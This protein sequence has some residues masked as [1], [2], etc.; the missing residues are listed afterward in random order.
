[1]R[2]TLGFWCAFLTIASVLSV[3]DK[4]AHASTVFSSTNLIVNMSAPV[5]VGTALEGI[6][7]TAVGLNGFQPNSFDGNSNDINGHPMTGITTASGNLLY[8]VWSFNSTLAQTPTLAEQSS[9]SP[10]E[11]PFD[12]HFLVGGSGPSIISIFPPT[13]NRNTLDPSQDANGGFG[14]SL[15]ATF[16]LQGSIMTSWDIA[17]VVVPAGTTLTL[18]FTVGDAGSG[19]AQLPNVWVNTTALV[20]PEPGSASLLALGAI[21]LGLARMVRRRRSK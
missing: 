17:Y 2:K 16:V 13:E 8:Q 12:T 1:M 21:G 20:V 18:D 10:G 14:N 6:T 11:V 9:L 5:P 7:L 4:G 15:T 3:P 19:H